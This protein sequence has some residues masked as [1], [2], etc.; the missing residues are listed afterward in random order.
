M[1]QAVAVRAGQGGGS[2]QGLDT[3]SD[4]TGAMPHSDAARAS[5][6]CPH[7]RPSHVSLGVHGPLPRPLALCPRL[8]Q[9]VSLRGR[10]RLQ[11]L[12]LA[13]HLRVLLTQR[14]W[15]RDGC[16]VSRMMES[17]KCSVANAGSWQPKRVTRVRSSVAE[18]SDCLREVI[19]WHALLTLS[20]TCSWYSASSDCSEGR[21]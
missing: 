7:E 15:M 12:G 17:I 1:T 4:N 9:L 5:I 3:C 14:L 19:T 13:Q 18:H 10:Q 11:S 20:S 8:H 6:G 16:C 2:D 21:M